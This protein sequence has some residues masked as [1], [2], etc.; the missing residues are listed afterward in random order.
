MRTLSLRT[1]MANLR[2]TCV[3]EFFQIFISFFSFPAFPRHTLGYIQSDLMETSEPT[4]ISL[5]YISTRDKFTHTREIFY[6]QVRQASLF[7]SLQV[8]IGTQM[9]GELK[10]LSPII[11]FQQNSN[12]H[13]LG[14]ATFRKTLVAP[15]GMSKELLTSNIHSH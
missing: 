12:V 5:S 15:D 7:L 6:H 3:G 14:R 2:Q 10:S 1:K 4:H 8:E 11:T 9:S 13:H